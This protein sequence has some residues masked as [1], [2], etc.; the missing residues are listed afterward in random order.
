MRN[1]YKRTKENNNNRF[2]EINEN[3]INK[4]WKIEGFSLK[5]RE[6]EKIK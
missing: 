5:Q 2:K 3:V 1:I 6:E 4:R